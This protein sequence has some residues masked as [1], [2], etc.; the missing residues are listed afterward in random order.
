MWVKNSVHIKNN[1]LKKRDSLNEYHQEV[2]VLL[3]F[4]RKVTEGGGVLVYVNEVSTKAK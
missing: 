1:K 4:E 2:F 3:Q